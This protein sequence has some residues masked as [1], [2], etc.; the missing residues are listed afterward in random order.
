MFLMIICC[1]TISI[2]PL[3]FRNM[4]SADIWQINIYRSVSWISALIL[5]LFFKYRTKI[6]KQIFA[7]GRWGI[8]AGVFLGSAQIFYM[9]A[10][11]NTTVANV[12]FILS[13]V[14]FVTA[15]IAYL[16]IKE[17]IKLPTIIMMAFA[18]IG[19]VIMVYEGISSGRAFGNLMAILT[20]LCFSCFPVI[21]RKNRHIDMLPTLIV[22]ALIIG[23][24]GFIIKGNDIN[25]S[26][27]D[28][29]LSFIW[30]GVLNGFAHAI[31]II[32]TRH[33]LAA[34]ITLFMLL[35]FTLGPLWVWYFVGEVPAINTLYGGGIV[36]SAI[37]MLTFYELW[38]RKKLN[39]IIKEIGWNEN[40]HETT[41]M[42][43]NNSTNENLTDL[44]SKLVKQDI[45]IDL[46][47]ENQIKENIKLE[48]EK[49]LLPTL[50]KWFEN[51]LKKMIKKHLDDQIN[52]LKKNN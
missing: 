5:I 15:L 14:P 9:H 42:T 40:T 3:L 2:G 1:I 8:I 4:E 47:K 52:E 26:D 37:A 48:I 41:K 25:I 31:F 18:A 17:T 7:I 29:I 36:M 24:V 50:N 38:K 30:G 45:K 44:G 33:L 43:D 28:I 11:D 35:E 21:L 32:A 19:I 20:L 39:N 34:E 10:L 16:F 13:S 22:P 46:I 23:L 6:F 49:L 51:D 27:N 12:L